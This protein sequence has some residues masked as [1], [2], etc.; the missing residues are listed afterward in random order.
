MQAQCEYRLSGLFFFFVVGFFGGETKGL[1][2]GYCDVGAAS[3]RRHITAPEAIKI[4]ASVCIISAEQIL[5]LSLHS[6]VQ[7]LLVLA[8]WCKCVKE[9]KVGRNDFKS[10]VLSDFDQYLG[11]V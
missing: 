11:M 1:C 7:S 10:K 8:C 3:E 2:N 6:G 5:N 9:A 4:C